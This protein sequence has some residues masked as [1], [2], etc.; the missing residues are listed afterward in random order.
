M[1][2]KV[3]NSIISTL[4]LQRSKK[5]LEKKKSAQYP[6]FEAFDANAKNMKKKRKVKSLEERHIY[7]ILHVQKPQ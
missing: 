3:Y 7:S 6:L 4:S 1:K 5:K 2:D